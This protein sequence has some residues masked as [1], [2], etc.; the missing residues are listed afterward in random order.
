MAE[1]AITATGMRACSAFNRP[2]LNPTSER[3]QRWFLFL[4]G[5]CAAF[6]ACQ[7]SF[8]FLI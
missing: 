2:A 4:F 7:L 3:N 1:R 8:G 5:D 6:L